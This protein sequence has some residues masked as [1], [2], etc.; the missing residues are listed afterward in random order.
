M[1]TAFIS[2]G[3]DTGLQQFFFTAR[4]RITKFVKEVLESQDPP[5]AFSE[6]RANILK[7]AEQY[8][9]SSPGFSNELRA[10]ASKG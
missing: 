1:N 6:H 9:H 2:N 10:I 7:L 4:R 3:S 8:E 5:C